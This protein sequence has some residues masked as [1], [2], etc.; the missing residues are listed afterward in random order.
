[1]AVTKIVSGSKNSLI[2]LKTR[3]GLRGTSSKSI[4]RLS[5]CF[6]SRTRSTQA[7]ARQPVAGLLRH[8]AQHGLGVADDA[9]IRLEDPA[10]LGRLDVDLDEA[11]R[12]PVDV[13]GAVVAVGETSAHREHQ[14]TLQEDLVGEPLLGLD[15]DDAGVERMVLRTGS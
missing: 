15:A 8:G 6:S 5:V 14:V 3:A 4:R 1:M 2:S 7:P 12:P 9:Q 10:D 13:E 11:A